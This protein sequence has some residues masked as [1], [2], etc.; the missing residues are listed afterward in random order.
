MFRDW[1]GVKE[2]VVITMFLQRRENTKKYQ[3]SI[4]GGCK[5]F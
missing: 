1:K 4:L 5:L 3:N 2:E